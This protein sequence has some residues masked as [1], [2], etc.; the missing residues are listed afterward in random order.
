MVTMKDATV[1]TP[2]EITVVTEEVEERNIEGLKAS[3]EDLQKELAELSKEEE[4]LKKKRRIVALGVD[5][6]GSL[7]ITIVHKNESYR[8]SSPEYGVRFMKILAAH[9]GYEVRKER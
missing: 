7:R 1:S 2:Q 4:E 5:D 6:Q 8:L 3:L 9:Y